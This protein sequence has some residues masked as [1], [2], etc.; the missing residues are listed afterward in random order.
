MR[1]GQL[2][3]MCSGDGIQRGS[4]GLVAA[5]AAE[6]TLVCDGCAR[7]KV[8]KSKYGDPEGYGGIIP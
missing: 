4:D 5:R 8:C 6:I 3:A 2:W 7:N 1:S